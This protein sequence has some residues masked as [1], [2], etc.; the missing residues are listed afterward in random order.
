[1]HLDRSTAVR[2]RD[3]DDD[4]AASASPRR[5]AAEHQLAEGLP[6]AMRRDLGVIAR[7]LVEVILVLEEIRLQNVFK[8]TT[9]G[10]LL[11]ESARKDCMMVTLSLDRYAIHL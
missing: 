10:S 6:R 3:D 9:K 7:A 1:M 11:F 8:K 4:C 2:Q 5:I